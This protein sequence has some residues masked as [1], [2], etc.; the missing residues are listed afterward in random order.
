MRLESVSAG[1]DVLHGSG[2]GNSEAAEA[3]NEVADRQ[4]AASKDVVIQSQVSLNP[5][6]HVAVRIL[7]R[8]TELV[9]S[10]GIGRRNSS[11]V[12]LELP[13]GAQRAMVGKGAEKKMGKN[14]RKSDAR[15]KSKIV[16]GEW[17]G[18]LDRELQ[19]QE[20]KNLSVKSHIESIEAPDLSLDWRDN[21]AFDHDSKQ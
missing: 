5:K 3:V 16:L 9:G 10:N 15:P 1:K 18:G 13:K 20:K 2:S 19:V 4:G 7:E 21:K 11:G 17:L 6:N 12:G 14:R 8:G